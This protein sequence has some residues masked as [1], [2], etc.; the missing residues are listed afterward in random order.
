MRKNYFISTA[1]VLVSVGGFAQ[2][3]SIHLNPYKKKG[4]PFDIL[5]SPFALKD[6][7]QKMQDA[8]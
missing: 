4:N 6:T 8:R 3:P 1:I 5:S 2:A 7:R